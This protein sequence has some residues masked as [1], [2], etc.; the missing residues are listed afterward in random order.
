MS[1]DKP[2]LWGYNKFTD[3]TS[4]SL[5]RLI[6]ITLT[7]KHYSGL[8]QATNFLTSFIIWGEKA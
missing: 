2:Y 6:A 5:Q 3:E 8:L 1:Y 7:L 4:C